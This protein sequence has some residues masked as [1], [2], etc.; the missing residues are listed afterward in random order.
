M[1]IIMEVNQ[2]YT[3]IS[4]YVYN[5]YQESYKLIKYIGYDGKLSDCFKETNKKD[6][7]SSA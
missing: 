7:W 5:N 6:A 3:S 2:Y 4:A 1:D